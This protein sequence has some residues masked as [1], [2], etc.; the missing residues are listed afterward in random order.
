MGKKI[1]FMGL[2]TMGLPMA[3]NLKKAAF[4]DIGYDAFKGSYA[5]AR[6]AGITMVDT[7]KEM[8]E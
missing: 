2:G 1:G 4:E 5:K 7:L 8:A 6:A 3:A